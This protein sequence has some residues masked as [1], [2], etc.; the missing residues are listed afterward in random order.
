MLKNINWKKT[1]KWSVIVILAIALWQFTLLILPFVGIW[2]VWKKTKYT[3]NTK[4]LLTVILIGII[5]L[6]SLAM[7]EGAKQAEIDKTIAVAILEP[8]NNTTTT[9]K[10]ITIKG[11]VNLDGARV[12]INGQKVQVNDKNFEYTASLPEGQATNFEVVAQKGS[13]TAK[14]TLAIT[15]ELSSEEKTERAKIEAQKE[16]ER[17]AQEAKEA[18][19]KADLEKKLKT[20][21]SKMRIENDDMIK[22]VRYEDK[23]SPQYRNVNGFYL[24]ITE[25]P[26]TGR[27]LTL[28]LQYSGSDWLFINGYII[29]ADDQTFVLT[30]DKV[31]R[32]NS[33][34]VW[35]WS[36]FTDEE[37]IMPIV[38]A[39][40][41]SKEAK[42]RYQGQQYYKDRVITATEKQALQNVLDAMVALK[43]GVKQ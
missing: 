28:N 21:L 8:L 32:D 12:K 7:Q 9:A 17:K 31:N 34:Y 43:M 27:Y 18:Q 20:A 30:P 38:E 4:I 14:T 11:N 6:G 39:V 40:I 41:K 25:H 26:T 16:A 10:S 29:K 35:E 36:T 13:Y 22:A 15:N 24:T 3:K 42:V 37:E 2:C 5:F 23:T 1:I 19:I 33:N